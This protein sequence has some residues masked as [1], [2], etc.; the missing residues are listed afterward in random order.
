LARYPGAVPRRKGGGADPGANPRPGRTGSRRT[1]RL[2]AADRQPV[3]DRRSWSAER[4]L[5]D[6]YGALGL[7][8]EDPESHRKRPA[9]PTLAPQCRCSSG[10]CATCYSLLPRVGVRRWGLIRDIGPVSKS[11]W[12]PGLGSTPSTGSES[13]RW[14]T[15]LREPSRFRPTAR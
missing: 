12:S 7:A 3:Q 5:P 14:P 11:R 9:P 6:R 4:P 1:E 2:R 8:D 13:A 10:T 15:S